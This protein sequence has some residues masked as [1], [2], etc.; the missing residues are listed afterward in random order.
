MRKLFI[1]TLLL[2]YSLSNMGGEPDGFPIIA[3]VLHT[4]LYDQKHFDEIKNAGF[5]ACL[6]RCDNAKEIN[7]LLKLAQQKEIKVIL[8][9]NVILGAP[10][11]IVPEIKHYNSLWQYYLADE[12]TMSRFNELRIYQRNIKKYDANAKCYINLLPNTG[13][14]LLKDIGVK[15]YPEYL[16]AYSNIS[17]PQIS[18]DF[19]PVHDKVVRDDIWYPILDDIRSES[20]RTGRPFWAYIMCVPH[21]IYPMPT[22]G[23]LRLQCFVNLAY[24]A[25]GIQYFSYSTPA[26]VGDYDFHDGPLLRNGKLSATY[27]LVKGMNEALKPVAD[28]FFH[29]TVTSIEHIKCENGN[30]LVSHF[31]KKGIRHTCFV[32][33]SPYKGVSVEIDTN[34]Y[35]KQ[36][37]K[38]MK[39]KDVK[40]RYFIHAGDILILKDK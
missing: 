11:T 35:S 29:S 33:K 30:V 26:P 32:N 36:I 38:S 18:Y 14:E 8:F 6:C 5:N 34:K 25:Q 39:A 27:K 15:T 12:P 4:S 2:F 20:I 19:Y 1:L 13:R 37:P 40:S 7:N 28:L 9:S 16:K 24:G 21:F 10:Q 31:Q 22:M 17:Q 23:H 3:D